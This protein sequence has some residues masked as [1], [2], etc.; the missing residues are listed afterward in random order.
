MD[1]NK[2]FA[3]FLKGWQFRSFSGR[4]DYMISTVFEIAKFFGYEEDNT[5]FEEDIGYKHP[6]IVDAVIKKDVM[7]EPEIVV[8]TREMSEVKIKEF[9]S[10][11]FDECDAILAVFVTTGMMRVFNRDKMKKIVFS[12]ATEKSLEKVKIALDIP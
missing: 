5:Y 1:T 3:T 4:D 12:K 6:W 7:D 10:K 9:A 2:E 11:I 8:I